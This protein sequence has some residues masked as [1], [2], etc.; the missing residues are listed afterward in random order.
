MRR[1]LVRDQV[2][3]LGVAVSLFHGFLPEC[4]LQAQVLLILF[5]LPAS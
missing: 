5:H 2:A 1:Y 4:F 3:G